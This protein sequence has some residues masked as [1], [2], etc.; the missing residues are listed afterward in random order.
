MVHE[1]SSLGFNEN[2][3]KHI[4]TN[5]QTKQHTHISTHILFLLIP[6]KNSLTKITLPKAAINTE[7]KRPTFQPE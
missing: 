1:L 5:S 6:L 2:I 7:L 4:F 3:Y